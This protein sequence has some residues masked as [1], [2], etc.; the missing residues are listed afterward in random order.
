[1]ELVPGKAALSAVNRHLQTKYRISVTPAGIIAATDEDEIPTE[2]RNLLN[3]L[4]GFAAGWTHES[5][6]RRTLSQ[7]M[8]GDADLEVGGP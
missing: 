7:P 4:A 5:A 6:A 1:M 2:M 3:E 8:G